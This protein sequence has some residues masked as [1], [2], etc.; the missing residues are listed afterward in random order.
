MLKKGIQLSYKNKENE[1][2]D[3]FVKELS[4]SVYLDII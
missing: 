2:K 1:K 4:F 3:S